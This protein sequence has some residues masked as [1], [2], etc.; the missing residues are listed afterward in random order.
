MG[1]LRWIGKIDFS[2]VCSAETAGPIKIRFGMGDYVDDAPYASKGITIR[3]VGAAPH[4][5]AARQC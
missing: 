1:D 4:I 3:P 5:I 2:G